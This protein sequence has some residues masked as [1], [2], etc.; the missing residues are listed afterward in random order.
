MEDEDAYYDR[1]AEEDDEKRIA[2]F[3]PYQEW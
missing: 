2:P 3:F 1:L